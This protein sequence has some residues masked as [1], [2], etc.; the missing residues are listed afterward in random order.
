MGRR[1]NFSLRIA[2]AVVL[3]AAVAW[4]V[5]RSTVGRYPTVVA[6]TRPSWLFDPS[7]PFVVELGRG[8]GW[9]GLDVVLLDSSGTVSMTRQ[10]ISAN[11]MVWHCASAT[12]GPAQVNRIAVSVV[13]LQPH[14]MGR[15]YS[16]DLQDGCQWV[17]RIEQGGREKSIYFNNS[18]P[19]PVNV[20][21]A[22]IDAEINGLPTPPTWTPLSEG[23][24]RQRESRL[25]RS[26]N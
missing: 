6:D 20:F 1:R 4:L 9:H 12:L 24:A 16:S 23:E 8:S 18:F 22:A 26:I 3:A 7:R 25:W 21:A 13:D 17:L 5:V 19:S 14:T 15:S 11:G 10:R 2:I